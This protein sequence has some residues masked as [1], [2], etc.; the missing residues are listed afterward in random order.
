MS[1]AKPGWRAF[2]A[3]VPA[4]A[5]SVMLTA[6]QGAAFPGHE[7]A[8][9]PDSPRA[10]ASPPVRA[11]YFRTKAVGAWRSLPT[12]RRCAA[13]VHRSA[14]EPRPDNAG[15]NGRMPSVRKVH[16]AFAAR[17]LSG[18]G[19]FKRRWDTWLLPRVTGHYTGTTDEIFQWAA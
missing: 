13:R 16:A 4:A 8:M 17:P 14:W 5:L 1:L 7:P 12:G 18:D 9:R 3:V 10:H 15:P 2:L 6:G 19:S 11:G